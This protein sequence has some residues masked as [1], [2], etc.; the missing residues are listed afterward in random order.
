MNLASDNEKFRSLIAE[1]VSQVG[2]E[3]AFL[4]PSRKELLVQSLEHIAVDP[5]E[6]ENYLAWLDRHHG[7][8]SFSTGHLESVDK[9][10]DILAGGLSC[11]G[12]IELI[13][14]AL[15]PFQIRDICD[16]FDEKGL[17]DYW[18][19]LVT[20]NDKLDDSSSGRQ[21]DAVQIAIMFA[22]SVPVITRHNLVA[23]YDDSVDENV[24][25]LNVPVSFGLAGGGPLAGPAGALACATLLLEE[26]ANRPVAEPLELDTLKQTINKKLLDHDIGDMQLEE[27][28]GV[29][30][31]IKKSTESCELSVADR[32]SAKTLRVQITREDEAYVMSLLT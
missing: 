26:L 16:A 23:W 1:L 24:R 29:H 7:R 30:D 4:S 3:E 20:G 13:R 2:G 22:E 28:S 32:I 10:D 21:T 9:L 8:R 17:S 6:M 25:F 5:I 18:W 12:D 14:F 19:S 31:F 15:S 27:L 11:L